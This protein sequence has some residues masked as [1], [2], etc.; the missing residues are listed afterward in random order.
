MRRNKF[1]VV[2]GLYAALVTGCATTPKPDPAVAAKALF[3]QTVKQYHLPSAE[4]QGPEHAALLEKAAAGYQRLL[5]T[6]PHQTNYC[7]QALRSL[8][9]V[10]AEQ[11]RLNDAVRLYA[12]VGERYP[13][14]EWE[15]LQAWKSA[16]DLLWDA[17]RQSEA[18]V[19][20]TK[21]GDRFNQPDA[22]AIVKTIVH[23][24]AGRCGK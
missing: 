17:G 9:N 14:M 21:I 19:F 20:Y 11:G 23:A 10:R 4:I 7:A 3:D 22:P 2:A 24:A 5:D 18:R 12:R 15:V 13:Q 8:A 6:Y 16:A 1:V